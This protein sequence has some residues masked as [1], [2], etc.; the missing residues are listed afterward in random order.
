[1]ES[2]GTLKLGN[3]HDFMLFNP[4]TSLNDLHTICCVQSCPWGTICTAEKIKLRCRIKDIY[5]FV[6]VIIFSVKKLED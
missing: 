1:M 4:T 2:L 6:P 3:V 5:R